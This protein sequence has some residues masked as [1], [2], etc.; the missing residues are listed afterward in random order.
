MRYPHLAPVAGSF[1]LLYN[2]SSGRVAV[3]YERDLSSDAAEKVQSQL[4][5]L[6]LPTLQQVKPEFE[7]LAHKLGVEMS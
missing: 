3:N 2:D 6:G 1:S 4:R 5:D 7:K